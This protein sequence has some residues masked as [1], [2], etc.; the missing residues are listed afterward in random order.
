M[1]Y[2]SHNNNKHCHNSLFTSFDSVRKINSALRKNPLV[3]YTS[4]KYDVTI[5]TTEK[6][7]SI[8]F[9]WTSLFS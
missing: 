3:D 2:S 1:T 6:T 9:S 5:W 8:Y 7:G 4:M